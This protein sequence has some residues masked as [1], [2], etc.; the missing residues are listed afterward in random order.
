M[1]VVSRP[2]SNLIRCSVGQ[3]TTCG[4]WDKHSKH[5]EHGMGVWEHKLGKNNKPGKVVC[6]NGYVFQ[7][8]ML[9]SPSI[10]GYGKSEK[11]EMCTV[12]GIIHIQL[13]LIQNVLPCLKH[14]QPPEQPVCS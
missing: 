11:S 3:E 10:S 8:F 13:I 6:G 12:N 2:E 9:N 4:L 7:C 14:S 5:R 1:L